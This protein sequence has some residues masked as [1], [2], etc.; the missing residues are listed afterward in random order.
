MQ[1]ELCRMRSDQPILS[2][3]NI[4]KTFGDTVALH[5]VDF[6]LYAGEVH[7]LVGEN[8]AGKSTLIKILAGAEV[9]NRGR[10]YALGGEYARLTPGES[11]EIGISTVYQDVE[12]IESLTV[13]D[14]I[15]LG[16]EIKRS[17]WRIDYKE[18]FRRARELMDGLKI[19]IPEDEYVERLSPADKQTLQVVKAV[20]IDAKILIMDE[21]TASLGLEEKRALMELVRT[22]RDRGIGIIY[23]SH[24][25]EEVF[26][27]GDR[28]T[29]LKDG[30]AVDHFEAA[31]VD[32]N[33]V[34]TS[35][36]GRSPS[37]FYN[38]EKV[39]LGEVIFEVEGLT[40]HSLVEEVSFSV[41][42]GEIFGIGG[43]VGAGRTEL[44][45]VLF[46]IDARVRGHVYLHGAEITPDNPR[47]AIARGLSMIVEDRQLLALFPDRPLR[48][49]VSIVDN[50]RQRFFLKRAQ[51][52]RLVDDLIGRLDI[53]TAG[54]DQPAGYLSGGNQQKSVIARW[55]PVDAE[56]YVFDE[57]TKGVDIGAKEEIYAFMVE[58]AK[59]GKCVLMVSSDMPELI[60]L[61]DRIGVMRN[62]RMV[63]VVESAETS[64]EELLNDFLGLNQGVE[65]EAT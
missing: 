43:I 4:T 13:A 58:L 21:P 36:V 3:K 48:E 32:L 44:M 30:E 11:L 65:R 14:N 52:K 51:E 35:M 23:I 62:G 60:S 9:P 64:E 12:L 41:R 31:D 42:K 61:S 47:Q 19:E 16:E 50:E 27:I 53:E 29:V 55:L 46:G 22:L 59:R 25:L 2:V 39:P 26:E 8:G 63:R 24:Y 38:R 15:F 37:V 6:D 20:H 28:I 45:N 5:D 1:E 34:A 54:Q 33:T 18:Q 57:P 40:R 56:V 49:N 17:W 10:L 7:C